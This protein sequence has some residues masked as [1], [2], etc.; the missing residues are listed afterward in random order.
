MKVSH[1]ELTGLCRRA[2]E[3]LGF[4]AGDHEDAADM[5]VWLEQHG[6][7][8]V[9]ALRR[10]L[11]HL[12]SNNRLAVQR[13]FEDTSLA[14]INAA[15]NSVLVCGSLAADLVYAKARRKG[16]AVVKLQNCYNRI[17]MLG[18]LARCARRGMNLLAFWRNSEDPKVVEQ[19]VSIRAYEEYP[20]LL[21][22]EV[23]DPDD[24][25]TRNRSVT[26]IASP[27]FSMLQ[28]LY[29]DP[30]EATLLQVLGPD[31]CQ[32]QS[33]HVLDHG[34]EVDDALWQRLK[35]LSALTLVESSEESRAR[36]AGEGS[37]G[38]A[39]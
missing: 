33:R 37:V 13:A 19:V 25:F 5:V 2:F 7:G 26:L 27:H 6:L 1:N 28:A 18:Y 24:N 8:G 20:T 15:D 4:H 3:G 38:S 36:G 12:A 9:D 22:Y 23:E 11:D 30:E 35:E 34:M 16:L 31:D 39:D 29:P 21:L 17:L 32:R 10:G 14:V